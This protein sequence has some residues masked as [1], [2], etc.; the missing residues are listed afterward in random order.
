MNLQIN[1]STI[2][3]FQKKGGVA[4]LGLYSES[5]RVASR[6]ATCPST[7]T[8]FLPDLGRRG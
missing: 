7:K 1:F 3:L 5:S 2:V 6:G 8:T 4:V